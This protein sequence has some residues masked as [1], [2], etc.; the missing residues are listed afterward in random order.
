[1]C[2]ALSSDEEEGGDEDSNGATLGEDG[3]E[4][5]MD[6][7]GECKAFCHTCSPFSVDVPVGED[8]AHGWGI[9]RYVCTKVS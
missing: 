3:S 5:K 4:I 7:N 8:T 2:I 1:M 9:F 6:N